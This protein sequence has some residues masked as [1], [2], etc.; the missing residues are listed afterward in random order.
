MTAP[1]IAVLSNR[2]SMENGKSRDLPPEVSSFKEPPR[3]ATVAT[4]EEMEVEYEKGYSREQRY[5][6]CCGPRLFASVVVL[7]LILVL[8]ACLLAFAEPAPF[9]NVLEYLVPRN[10][11]D[12]TEMGRNVSDMQH[13]HIIDLPPHCEEG[14]RYFRGKCRKVF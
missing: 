5:C 7:F 1:S 6:H 12:D 9:V 14:F 4:S 10:G 8:A 3:S 13:A 2:G 11:S